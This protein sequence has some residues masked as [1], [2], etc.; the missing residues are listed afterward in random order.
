MDSG[1]QAV[2]H[3][4]EHRTRYV[5]T[6]YTDN[7]SKKYTAF[8]SQCNSNKTRNIKPATQI[9]ELKSANNEKLQ[10]GGGLQRGASLEALQQNETTSQVN[11]HLFN[12]KLVDSRY[13]ESAIF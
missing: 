3:L 4:Q 13:Y 1:K 10:P 11:H 7:R 6:G 8:P 2:G 12:I 5:S 9:C